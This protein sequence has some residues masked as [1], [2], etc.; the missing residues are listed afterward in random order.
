MRNKRKRPKGLARATAPR[1]QALFRPVSPPTLCP[2]CYDVLHEQQICTL[3]QGGYTILQPRLCILPPTTQSRGPSALTGALGLRSCGRERHTDSRHR[4]A[5]ARAAGRPVLLAGCTM[6]GG[7]DTRHGKVK[8]QPLLLYAILNHLAILGSRLVGVRA[9]GHASGVD[10]LKKST[11]R[12]K[13]R[14]GGEHDVFAAAICS[15]RAAAICSSFFRESKPAQHPLEEVW[16]AVRFEHYF[17][18]VDTDCVRPSC[19]CW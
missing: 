1:N 19:R 6:H 4:R 9:D 11:L 5:Q 16:L 2:S 8:V 3:T 14:R 10:H 17:V 7:I 12:D 18:E 15:S 13:R